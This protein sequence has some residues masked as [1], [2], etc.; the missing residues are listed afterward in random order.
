MLKK[1]LL[2]GAISVGTY[3]V[4]GY[5]PVQWKD[6]GKTALASMNLSRLAPTN[7]L[8][9]LKTKAEP[10]REKLI[11]ESPVKKRE[12]LI[13]KLSA[14]LST[15]ADNPNP[16]SAKE[17]LAVETATKE[18]QEILIQLKEENPKSGIIA[19]V[20][21]RIIETILPPPTQNSHTVSSNNSTC[22]PN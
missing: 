4:Y 9:E 22:Q 15:I 14:N 17:R 8:P 16:K 21:E 5:M 11:P 7:L 18:S 6:Q 2:I 3:F 1:L 19:S 20:T 10:Y 12:E 13:E